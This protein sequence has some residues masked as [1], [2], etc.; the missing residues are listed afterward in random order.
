MQVLLD[1]VKNL[2]GSVFALLGQKLPWRVAD[3]SNICK[4]NVQLKYNFDH[5][6]TGFGIGVFVVLFLYQADCSE[7]SPALRFAL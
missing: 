7:I 1:E 5:L 2:V 3:I 4:S 6:G